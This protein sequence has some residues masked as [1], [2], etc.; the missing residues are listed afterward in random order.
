MRQLKILS[1]VFL[2][3][4]AGCQGTYN[5]TNNCLDS[6]QRPD[7]TQLQ[8]VNQQNRQLWQSKNIQAYS[9]TH[10]VSSWVLIEPVSVTVQNGE[11]VL[12]PDKTQ[13][14]EERQRYKIESYFDA[15]DQTSKNPRACEM[16]SVEYDAANG[17]PLKQDWAL[18]DKGIA[19]GFGGYQNT[20]FTVLP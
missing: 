20:N 2:V 9:Y 7:W 11:V 15:I 16:L 13:N 4:L 10:Q 1:L 6:Y 17:F 19:D 5:L 8:K 14:L 12:S 18:M 3:L